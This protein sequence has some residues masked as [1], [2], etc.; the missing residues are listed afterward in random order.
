MQT[1]HGTAFRR[2][3][4]YQ[5]AGVLWVR[6]GVC[7]YPAVGARGYVKCQYVGIGLVLF[8]RVYPW[9][10]VLRIGPVSRAWAVSRAR[11]AGRPSRLASVLRCSQPAVAAD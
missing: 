3:R 11:S 10:S 4:T 1:F 2:G 7:A 8:K 6:R 9:R 5:I